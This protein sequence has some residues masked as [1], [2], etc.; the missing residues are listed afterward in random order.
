[1]KRD[2]D[3]ALRMQEL[4]RTCPGIAHLENVMTT[5][6]TTIGEIDLI[7]IRT[8]EEDTECRGISD[9]TAVVIDH[10]LGIDGLIEV[11]FFVGNKDYWFHV[12]YDGPYT[13]ENAAEIINDYGITL[14]DALREKFEV[15]A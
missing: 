15:R 13:E 8:S 3:F 14:D 2:N 9:W 10:V 5:I 6:M 7:L 4:R 11:N 12:V 1:M